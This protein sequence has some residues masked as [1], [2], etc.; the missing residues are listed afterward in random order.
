[1]L[2]AFYPI[3]DRL[4]SNLSIIYNLVSRV[5]MQLNRKIGLIVTG[6]VFTAVLVSAWLLSPDGFNT[7][8]WWVGSAV[9]HQLPDHSFHLNGQQF[10]LCAR[11]TGTYLSAF[12]ALLYFMTRGKRAAIP[13]KDL[14]VVFI[15][16]SLFWVIDG[17][18]S[19]SFEVLHQQWFYAPSNL[20]RFLSGIT[21]GMTFALTIM[22][23]FNMVFWK[24]TQAISLVKDQREFA[25][26]LVVESPLLFFPLNKITF[27]F[28]LA[29]LFS[30]LTVLTLIALLY[31][32]LIVIIAHKEGSY[33]SLLDAS[34]P[35]LLG[36]SAAIA[37][38]FL[39]VHLRS[40]ISPSTIFHL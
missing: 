28:N 4:A 11:C 26:L 13:R 7:K 9:C 19:F 35:L 10:P 15:L 31:A 24:N 5:D 29:G 37:Q 6:C 32:I 12:I 36:F 34:V 25:A 21:M 16:F 18:N 40:A 3:N 23:I 1:M 17:I 20:L 38:I 14:L 39:L 30:T 33:A 2:R 22:T 8:L 27:I